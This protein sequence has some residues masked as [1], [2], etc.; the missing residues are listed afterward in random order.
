MSMRRAGITMAA[1]ALLALAPSTGLA[2]ADPVAQT[3]TPGT[4][5]HSVAL[6][7]QLWI[8]GSGTARRVTYWTR[9]SDDR[10]ALSTGAVFI[11]AGTAPSGGWPVLSW[12]HGTVGLGDECAPSTAGRSKRDLDYLAH[13]MRQGYAAPDRETGLR[14]RTA[15]RPARG[16]RVSGQGSQRD[17]GHVLARQ[18]AVRRAP[19]RLTP[20]PANPPQLCAIAGSGATEPESVWRPDIERIDKRPWSPP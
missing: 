1:A 15:R 17:D 10:P 2:A 3:E 14:S 13:W 19:V 8:V 9:T 7:E 20:V 18:H 5:L 6:P 11:P 4:V 12:E 16:P